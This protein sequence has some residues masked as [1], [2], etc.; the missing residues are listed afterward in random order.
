MEEG[1]EE[2]ERGNSRFLVA[3][4]QNRRKRSIRCCGWGEPQHLGSN[5]PRNDEEDRSTKYWGCGGAGHI[6]NNCPRVNQKDPHRA[7]VMELKKECSHRK[8]SADGNIDAPP[9]RHF[10]ENS[11][12]SW[13][14]ENKFGVIDPVVRQV[15]MPS[16][17]ES[18]PW[19]DESVQVLVQH[20]ISRYGV[21][22]QLH[23]D[24][25]KN[26]DSA[27]CKRLC[28]VLGIDK[29]RTTALHPLSN[30]MVERFNRTILNSLSLLVS[31]NPQEW[32]KK[33]PFFPACLQECRSRDH[34][35][36]PIPDYGRDRLPSDVLFHQMLP[37]R[38]RSMSRNSRHE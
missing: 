2:I 38:L 19:S 27:V 5:C 26:F 8:G 35:L 34:R 25:G 10:P 37:W 23:S 18:D 20:W 36:F 16:T 12:Y 22:L 28:E 13:R 3:Q 4:R 24:Q 7:S 15:T 30:G 17:S 31:S 6:R 32:D 11:K 29:T 21:P 14:V 9:R 1:D 33:L